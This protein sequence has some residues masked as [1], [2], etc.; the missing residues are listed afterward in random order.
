MEP[1]LDLWELTARQQGQSGNSAEALAKLGQFQNFSSRQYD[2]YVFSL[3]WRTT[4]CYQ[5]GVLPVPLARNNTCLPGF[6][7][8]SDSACS[9]RKVHRWRHYSGCHGY[10]A[11]NGNEIQVRTPTSITLLNSADLRQNVPF[12]EPIKRHATR[13]ASSSLKCAQMAS[14]AQVRRTENSNCPVPKAHFA[15][16]AHKNRSIAPRALFAERRAS[17]N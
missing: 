4:G 6:Y 5:R 14:T 8:K 17:A 7:C 9:P 3:T 2:R 10:M 11:E 13:K 12:S 16:P 1:P 15:R